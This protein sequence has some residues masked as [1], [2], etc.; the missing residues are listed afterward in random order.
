MVEMAHKHKN[1]ELLYM[2]DGSF[3]LFMEGTH[4]GGTWK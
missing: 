2:L 3:N 4:S 1:Y